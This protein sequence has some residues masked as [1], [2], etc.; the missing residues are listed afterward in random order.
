MKFIADVM[1]GKLAKYLRMCSCDIQY[2]HN[3]E[4]KALIETAMHENRI[5]LTRDRLMLLRKEI[6]DGLIQYAYIKNETLKM[7]LKQIRDDF[8]IPLKIHFARCIKCNTILTEA[9]RDKIKK[10]VPEYIFQT[11][12]KFYYCS[13]CHKFYW[14]GTHKKNM[15][16]FFRENF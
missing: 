6:K 12:K 3:I 5:L 8:D 10:N 9:L 7:Q 14:S 11:Q 2:D 16:I 4:D 1:L 13:E 15:E